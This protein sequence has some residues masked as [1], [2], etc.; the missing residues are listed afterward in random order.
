MTKFGLLELELENKKERKTFFKL[1]KKFYY[2]KNVK[3]P[4]LN[5]GDVPYRKTKVSLKAYFIN[6]FL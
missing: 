6:F 1:W 4:F 3:C 5:Q 2:R